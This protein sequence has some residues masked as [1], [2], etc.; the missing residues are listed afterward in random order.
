MISR[1]QS[2]KLTLSVLGVASL[3]VPTM[4]A[5]AT[6]N[7]IR[8]LAGAGDLLGE[9]P[10]WSADTGRVMWVNIS[11]QKI[12][13]L[14]PTTGELKSWDTPKPVALLV[15]RQKGGMIVG[16]SDGLYEFD[17]DTSELTFLIAIEGNSDTRINDG[18]V[19]AKGRL[20]AGTMHMPWQSKVCGF[21][22]VDPD[23]SVTK[24]DGPYLCCNGPTFS[25]DGKH[26]WHN[27]TFDKMVFKFDVEAKGT[28]KNKREFVN[29]GADPEWGSPDGMTT[30]AK[31]GVWVAH[32]GGGR[33]SRFLPDGKLDF[34]IAM[35]VSQITSMVFGGDK[36]DHLYVTSAAQFLPEGAPDGALAGSLFEIPP[37]LLRG[38]T[39]LPTNKFA[40]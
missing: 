31:G 27:E 11:G 34:Q 18:K 7:G 36:L 26:L 13:A 24:V 38:H 15:E 30:D 1:R 23:L 20:W 2:L 22:R 12:H 16:L 9:G 8:T 5:A 39:G 40:G 21:Y 32:Y 28:L 14:N 17:Q 6:E 35:P 10:I 25:P 3:G 33:I 19:D 29:F 37:S 4:T